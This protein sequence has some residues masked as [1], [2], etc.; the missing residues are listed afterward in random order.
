MSNHRYH[1]PPTEKQKK[2]LSKYLATQEELVLVSSIGPRYL[3][4]NL[5]FLLIIP[6]GFFYLSIFMLFGVVNIPGF[7]WLKYIGLVTILIALF[8]LKST[9]AIL[10]K[11]QSNVY[12]VTNRRIL[13]ITG[14][15]S[16]KIVT[17]PL[18]RITHI[19][20]DQSFIQRSLYNTG[21]LLI[22]TA[23]FDQREIVVEHISNPIKFKVLVEELTNVS[24]KS[25]NKQDL[26]PSEDVQIRAISF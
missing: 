14:L 22:I 9:S 19:T 24:E 11:R 1:K 8:K 5:V 12:V 17:A 2:R 18:D 25:Q 26:P 6:L 3:W 20:V 16:R 7:D 13:I 21:H 4:I 10:R 15:F 23:G